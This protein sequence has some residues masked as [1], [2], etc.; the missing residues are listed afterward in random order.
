MRNPT[1]GAPSRHIVLVTVA[2]V[3]ALVAPSYAASD[4]ALV[5]WGLLAAQE[6]R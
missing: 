3:I 5:G 4:T 6:V 1:A 2:L